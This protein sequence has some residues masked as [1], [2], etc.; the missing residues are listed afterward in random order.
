MGNA[1]KIAGV[2]GLAAVIAG[3]GCA[4]YAF[5][6]TVKNQV[7]MRLD[8]PQEYF[9]WVCEKNI[10]DAA[11]KAG[12]A[13][14]RTADIASQKKAIQYALE[15][16]PT[17]D[18]K[19]AV[20]DEISDAQNDTNDMLRQIVEHTE[21]LGFRTE[22]ALS[23]K[24][25]AA[26][27]SLLVNGESVLSA[28]AFL[29]TDS[30]EAGFRIPDLTDRWFAVDTGSVLDEDMLASE[31]KFI[32]F[33]MNPTD[34]LSAG[35]V[36]DFVTGYMNAIVAEL[37]EPTLE[38]STAVAVAGMDTEYTAFSL[39]ITPDD[40][41]RI[42]QAMINEFKSD[43]VIRRL[44]VDQ[45]GILS[46]EDYDELFSQDVENAEYSD[47][48]LTFY[49]D[50]TG[51][52]RGTDI[53]SAKGEKLFACAAKDG[54]DIA[55]ALKADDEKH[56]L[57]DMTFRGTQD[58]AVSG[59]VAATIYTSH[60]KFDSENEE[61]TYEYTEQTLSADLSDLEIVDPSVGLV[62]GSITVNVP[63]IDPFTVILS[64][65]GSKQEISTA[66]AADG[67][68]Y[69][70]VKLS[71]GYTDSEL[72]AEPDLSNVYRI[73]ED[74]HFKLEDYATKDEFSTFMR[75]LLVKLGVEPELAE[76]LTS[77]TSK[78]VYFDR[79]AMLREFEEQSKQA[80]EQ[81]RAQFEQD[82][83]DLEAEADARYA[84]DLEAFRSS[85]AEDSALVDQHR[86]EAEAA[87]NDARSKDQTDFDRALQDAEAIIKQGQDA[88]NQG[89][90]EAGEK[91]RQ[92]SEEIEKQMK[93]IQEELK[94]IN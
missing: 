32:Q 42:E 57:C 59:K 28:D 47:V 5:S 3:G 79:E 66:V 37:P 40:A 89:T 81:A 13:W 72:S 23:G 71:Y 19:A 12:S 62:R 53:S 60:Y 80:S 8:D 78:E 27:L 29:N 9:E 49:A 39:H 48:D 46:A 84:E 82:A 45:L 63:E 11:G 36:S 30:G 21:T 75:N 85:A 1:V 61:D 15:Y 67:K 17:A 87:L 4:A 58:T 14:Q 50:A 70:D 43:N 90:D 92:G 10:A 44:Y 24:G 52:F 33:A 38:K 93:E 6:D 56:A 25:T 18:A 16:T 91:I 35:E 86:E 2:A 54:N 34:Y 88:V 22:G 77:Q 64:T 55:L 26:A 20:L 76:R 51:T 74:T 83:A 65:D 7:K 73:T 41:K 94:K 68:S 31:Q 69:G